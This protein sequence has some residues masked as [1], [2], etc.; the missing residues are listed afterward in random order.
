M[1]GANGAKPDQRILRLAGALN[2]VSVPGFL[3]A[4][5]KE[6]AGMVVIDFAGV[7][8]VDSAGVGSLIQTFVAFQNAGRKLALVGMSPRILAVL[9]ITRVRTL[10]PVFESLADAEA[11]LG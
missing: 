7:T 4:V 1:E 6:K 11:R 9:D 8:L 3:D 5:R 2:L 10:L